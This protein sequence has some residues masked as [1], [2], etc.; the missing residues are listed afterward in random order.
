MICFI[1]LTCLL[2]SELILQR[3]IQ[4]TCKSPLKAECSQTWA[5]WNQGCS[6]A[7]SAVSLALGWIT[8]S[9]EICGQ[10]KG[11]FLIKCKWEASSYITHWQILI[12]PCRA[13]Q[14][15]MHNFI[16]FMKKKGHLIQNSSL[17]CF[18]LTSVEELAFWVRILLSNIV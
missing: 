4:L 16:W 8:R 7:C 1:L 9:L 14:D 6:S 5:P 10:E 18:V 17:L 15:K 3:E 13:N 2:H 11:E 12:R